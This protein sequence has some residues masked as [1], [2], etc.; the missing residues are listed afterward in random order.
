MMNPKMKTTCIFWCSQSGDTDT[1]RISSYLNKGSNE[2]R[3]SL[4]RRKD[5]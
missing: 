1:E 4:K 3:V 2:C 5:L